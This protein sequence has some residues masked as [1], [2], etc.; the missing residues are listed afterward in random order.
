MSRNARIFGILMIVLL[1]SVVVSCSL[2]A[3][4][5]HPQELVHAVLSGDFASPAARIFWYVRLPRILA[6]ILAGAALSAS[7]LLLQSVLRNPLASPGVI[8]VNSG[9]G[10][11][12]LIVMAFLPAHTLLV[13]FAAFA[14]ACGAAFIVYLLARLS[15]ASRGTLADTR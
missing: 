15:G 6:A 2:G 3:S 10:L 12:A 8:G 4:G 13:P 14:G 1:L 11:C 5:I 9:A 7:G